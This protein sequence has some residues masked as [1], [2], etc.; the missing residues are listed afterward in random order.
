MVID[1]NVIDLISK[2]WFAMFALL[3]QAGTDYCYV[4]EFEYINTF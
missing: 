3:A 1:I 4:H 2:V